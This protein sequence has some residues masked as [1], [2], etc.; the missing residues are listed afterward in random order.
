M[1]L[2]C[3]CYNEKKAIQQF[4][5]AALNYP[6]L[7][8]A[9]CSDHFPV[10]D[11]II[12]GDTIIT[13]DTFYNTNIL[14]TGGFIFHRA[15]FPSDDPVVIWPYRGRRD[16]I[17][18]SAPQKPIIKMIVKTIKI[19]DTIFRE[20]KAEL[21]LCEIYNDKLTDL[22]VRKTNESDGFQHKAKK[23]GIIM[24][25]LIGFI[26]LIVGFNIYLKANKIRL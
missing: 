17:L 2:L 4:N 20:N 26:I 1:I 13:I 11:S 22:L 23:R 5:K 9:Y 10:R 3:G 14:D 16:S 19:I 8:A 6:R 7:P 24:W 18:G 12:K 21:K 15:P 25:S